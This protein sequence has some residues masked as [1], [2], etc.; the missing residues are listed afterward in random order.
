MV[1]IC[2]IPEKG[3]TAPTATSMNATF[4]SGPY[5]VERLT[6]CAFV[7]KCTETSASLA[8]T[9]KLQASNNAFLDNVQNETNSSATWADIAGATA[10]LTAGSVNVLLQATDA[11]YEAV[12]IVWTRTSGQGT[13]EIYFMAKE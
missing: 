3:K 5:L 2:R 7:I 13:A 10:T 8:G 1:N 9:F 12:R 6:Q 11:C 4:N